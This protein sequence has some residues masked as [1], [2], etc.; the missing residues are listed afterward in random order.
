MF[1]GELF[2]LVRDSFDQF[3]R[4]APRRV[5]VAITADAAECAL[6]IE[7]RVPMKLNQ[8]RGAAALREM[9]ALPRRGA[10]RS[11]HNRFE[12]AGEDTVFLEFNQINAKE[13]VRPLV[14]LRGGGRWCFNRIDQG[15]IFEAR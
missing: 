9:M 10:K 11:G 5:L 2:K 14:F 6:V 3:I 8:R 12:G 4:D 1:F 13:Q 15:R 7:R